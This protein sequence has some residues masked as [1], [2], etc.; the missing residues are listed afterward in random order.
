MNVELTSF[1]KLCQGG[2]GTQ[3][4]ISFWFYFIVIVIAIMI[5]LEH[6]NDNKNNSFV[7]FI[8]FPHDT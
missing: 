5:Y 3:N 2:F 1:R 7:S 4:D 8:Q 6:K